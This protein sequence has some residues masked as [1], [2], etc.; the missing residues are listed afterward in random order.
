MIKKIFIVNDLH[1]ILYYRIKPVSLR[2]M[3]VCVCV[4]PNILQP[5]CG[6]YG[7]V[8]VKF[9]YGGVDHLLQLAQRLPH[10]MDVGNLQEYQL[11]IGIE[12]F[13]LVATIFSLEKENKRED[14]VSHCYAEAFRSIYKI[15][16]S[17]DLCSQ[18][19]AFHLY[20]ITTSQFNGTEDISLSLSLPCWCQR[21]CSALHRIWSACVTARWRP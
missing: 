14:N 11:C 10:H 15:Y 2:V 12:T 13:A 8:P 5:V 18:I 3:C 1:F 17:V 7:R 19:Y 16:I 4:Y 21:H 20:R 9:V 6:I